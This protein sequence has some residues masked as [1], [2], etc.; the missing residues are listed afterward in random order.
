MSPEVETSTSEECTWG[1]GDVRYTLRDIR[2]LSDKV[3]PNKLNISE[4]RE[5]VEMPNVNGNLLVRRN[6]GNS[7]WP[8]NCNM[9]YALD[10]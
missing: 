6:M 3:T 10:F 7:H 4:T 1:D 8:P 2:P 9:E 5:M